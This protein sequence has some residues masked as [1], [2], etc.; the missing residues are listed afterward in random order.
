M[1]TFG[2]KLMYRAKKD[3]T[4]AFR[5]PSD[6]RKHTERTTNDKTQVP[7]CWAG[8]TLGTIEVAYMA[9]CLYILSLGVGCRQTGDKEDTDH[10]ERDDRESSISFD[11]NDLN[12][13]PLPP[14][15]EIL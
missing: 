10:L 12:K 5:P 11:G 9:E 7:Y 3:G 13:T 8:S 15:S 14:W 1:L 6:R 2:S 4:T